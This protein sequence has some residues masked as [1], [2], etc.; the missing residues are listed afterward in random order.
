MSER[1]TCWSITINNPSD[2][3]LCPTFPGG[4]VLTGQIE[5]GEQG[6]RHYQG[7]LTTPQVRVSAVKKLFRR[8][9]IELARNKQALLQYVHK[10][11]SRVE[12][13]PDH[14]SNIPT[15]FDYQHTV[16]NAFNQDEYLLFVQQFK[17]PEK[18]DD[19]F[20][21]YID[22]L[23]RRDIENGLCGVEFIAINPMW[24]SA[25]K[26]FGRS[27][28]KREQRLDVCAPDRGAHTPENEIVYPPVE[29]ESP[30]IL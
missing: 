27:M 15:L 17:T 13:V 8:A 5:V 24:R 7:A 2:E 14:V 4:W 29:I 23:V 18:E 11:E 30:H 1:G 21:G 16:A 26:K 22:D 9:H 10:D 3:E 28:I 6:T 19:L 12:L 20:M 25:W